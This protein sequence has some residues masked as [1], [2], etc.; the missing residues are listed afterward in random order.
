MQCVSCYARPGLSKISPAPLTVTELVLKSRTPYRSRYRWYYLAR[1]SSARVRAGVCGW[2]VWSQIGFVLVVLLLFV[3]SAG[4]LRQGSK[5]ESQ[6]RWSSPRC[7]MCDMSPTCARAIWSPSQ[8]MTE[9]L[10]GD[11]SSR[12]KQVVM[13]SVQ[14]RWTWQLRPR[15]TKMCFGYCV[16]LIRAAAGHLRAAHEKKCSVYRTL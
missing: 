12:S 2:C 13:L 6:H 3:V 16:M 15:N 7:C 4:V 5:C 9:P 14:R 1:R 10:H 8:Q 11:C